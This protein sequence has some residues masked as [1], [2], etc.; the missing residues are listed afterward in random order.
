MFESP[1]PTTTR[2]GFTIA[3]EIDRGRRPGTFAGRRPDDVLGQVRFAR[4]ALEIAIQSPG[5]AISTNR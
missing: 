1:R 3:F 2:A 5:A 4:A